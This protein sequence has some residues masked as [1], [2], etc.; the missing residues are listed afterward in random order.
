MTWTGWNGSELIVRTGDDNMP[1][2]LVCTGTHR[3]QS[4]NRNLPDMAIVVCY[5]YF[6]IEISTGDAYRFLKVSCSGRCLALEGLAGCFWPAAIMYRPPGR[7]LYDVLR[8]P[9]LPQW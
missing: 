2:L 8:I 6:S 1:Y 9:R 5:R 4:A 3:T 7:K